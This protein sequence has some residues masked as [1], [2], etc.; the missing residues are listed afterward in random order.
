MTSVEKNYPA[1][2]ADNP[3]GAL[4][5]RLVVMGSVVMDDK[6]EHLAV[7]TIN[8]SAIFGDVRRENDTA[9]T[10]NFPLLRLQGTISQK[11][12]ANTARLTPAGRRG[13]MA[14]T[15]M[16]A[17]HARRSLKAATV[18]GRFIGTEGSRANVTP[19]FFR[20]ISP[21]LSGATVIGIYSPATLHD[22]TL[23]AQ[24]LLFRVACNEQRLVHFAPLTKY[25]P[26]F[27][28][29]CRS[30]AVPR[31]C[32]RHL[33]SPIGAGHVMPSEYGSVKRGLQN[34]LCVKC[35]Q[36]GSQQCNS[37]DKGNNILDKAHF[38]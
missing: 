35:L 30:Y 32:N 31:F 20:A 3:A 12:C 36:R 25:D 5:H 27:S 15:N 10:T 38:P 29:R 7:R 4:H 13:I 6:P 23:R 24:C 17:L 34:A 28:L 37:R 33:L 26:P 2:R 19:R 8:P 9:N 22:L 1:G 18:P 21:V 16:A 11:T 14:K